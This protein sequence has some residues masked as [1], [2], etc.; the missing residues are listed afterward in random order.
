[1]G[2]SRGYAACDIGLSA[3]PDAQF[4]LNTLP[5]DDAIDAISL[6]LLRSQEAF[7]SV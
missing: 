6:Q 1:M 4:Q 3:E 5:D 7:F 2:K